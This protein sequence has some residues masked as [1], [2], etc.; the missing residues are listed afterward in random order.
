MKQ[1]K[2]RICFINQLLHKLHFL[3][4]EKQ[5]TDSFS[6]TIPFNSHINTNLK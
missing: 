4:E 6:M 3:F 2:E 1:Y 5:E